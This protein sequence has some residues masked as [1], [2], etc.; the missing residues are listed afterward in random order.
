MSCVFRPL[1]SFFLLLPV[2]AIYDDDEF[3]DVDDRH[4]SPNFPHLPRDLPP[5][6]HPA[7]AALRHTPCV[8]KNP[9]LVPREEEKGVWI[10]AVCVRDEG[11]R[12]QNPHAMFL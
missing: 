1:L 12:T 4:A 5:P 7:C 8:M 3:D 6:T 11:P 9:D 2:P 10:S